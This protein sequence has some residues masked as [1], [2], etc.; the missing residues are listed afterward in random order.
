MFSR[1]FKKKPEAEFA[2]I[3][4]VL[5]RTLPA[6]HKLQGRKVIGVNLYDIA[7]MPKDMQS[8]YLPEGMRLSMISKS[9]GLLGVMRGGE[10]VASLTRSVPEMLAPSFVHAMPHTLKDGTTVSATPNYDL[11]MDIKY[12]DKSI[13]CGSY[14]QVAVYDYAEILAKERPD[15]A[16][17]MVNIHSKQVIHRGVGFI[18]GIHGFTSHLDGDENKKLLDILALA[19][20]R[21]E[22][23]KGIDMDLQVLNEINSTIAMEVKDPFAKPQTAEQYLQPS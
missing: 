9:I 19:D 20:L 23:E 5:R 8:R 22:A 11:V 17:E 2:A 4:G 3:P 15:I 1:F 14:C 13:P 18:D 10:V 21:M 12:S 16:S 6:D 7:E